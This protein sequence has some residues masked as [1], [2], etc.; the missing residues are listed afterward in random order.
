VTAGEREAW[1]DRL[2][3]CDDPPEP[4]EYE[5]WPSLTARELGEAY[6]PAVLLPLAASQGRRGPGQPGSARAV[7]GESSSQAASFGPG[8]ALD[9]LAGCAQLAAAADTA[10]GDDDSY[11]GVSYAE[12]MGVLCAWDRLEAHMAARKLAAIAEFIRRCPD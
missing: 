2:A 3:E 9:V 1:L 6:E 4:E 11:D 7:P 5:D 10:A 8:M 12:L